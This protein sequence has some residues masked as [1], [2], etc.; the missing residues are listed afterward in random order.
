MDMITIYHLRDDLPDRAARD[1]CFVRSDED[2]GR[3]RELWNQDGY[4]QVAQIKTLDLER[5]YMLTQNGV[6]RDSWSQD[7]HDEIV[8]MAPN[9][10]L[11]GRTYGRRSTSV[12]DVLL[13]QG[14]LYVV[15]R[16]GFLP[17]GV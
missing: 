2:V 15:A 3:V 8:P 10:V 1:V 14:Q 6:V 4:I 13:C 7:A 12:G 11:N 9:L 16:F 17:L 5:A